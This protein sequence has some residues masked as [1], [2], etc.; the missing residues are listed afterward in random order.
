MKPLENTPEHV[1]IEQYRGSQST[2]GPTSGDFNILVSIPEQIEIKMV[3]ASALSDYEIWFFSSGGLLSFFSGFLVAWLQEKDQHTAKILAIIVCLL[4]VLFLFT[5]IMTLVK[6]NS[7]SKKSR[8]VY[9]RT[10]RASA[11]PS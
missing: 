9:L 6:R 1:E 10:S 3:D 7:M 8:K 5:F 4:A 2:P 11:Q